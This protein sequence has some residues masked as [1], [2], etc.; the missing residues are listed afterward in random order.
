MDVELTAKGVEQARL[1]AERLSGTRIDAVYSSDL[2][3]ASVTGEAIAAACGVPLATTPRLREACLGE[4]QGLTVREA[5]ERYPTEHAA[6]IQD[7][8]AN[9]PP[10]A[11][12]LEDVIARCALF[13]RETGAEHPEGYVA[14]AAHGGSIRG[15]IAAAFGLGPEIYRR[16][17]F[18]NGG[19]TLLEIAEGKPLLTSLNDTCHLRMQLIGD[20]VD[21]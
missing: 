17:R 21:V 5:A 10:G 18:D 13:L 15:I 8:I 1:V 11:E 6:Y 16:V 12:R 14:V 4:W 3:R 20:G 7:S 2:K 19:L 9:R